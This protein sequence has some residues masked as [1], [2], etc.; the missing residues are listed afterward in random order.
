MKAE[1]RCECFKAPP[2]F[3]CGAADL[4][5]TVGTACASAE[6][7][8]TQLIFPLIMYRAKIAVLFIGKINIF[9]SD[10]E[11]NKKTAEN[12]QRLRRLNSVCQD[13]RLKMIP[14][15]MESVAA[16]MT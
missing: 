16:A 2:L 10:A 15:A 13:L 4:N 9:L 7:F 8:K 5:S 1:T 3:I 11:T 6:G 14:R 12:G